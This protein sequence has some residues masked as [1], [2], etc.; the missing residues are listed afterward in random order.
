MDPL[1]RRLADA[2]EGL[3]IFT[4]AV[5]DQVNSDGTVNLRLRGGIVTNVECLEFYSPA[6]GDVVQAVRKNAAQYLVFGK[7]R[8]SAVT[9]VGVTSALAMPWKIDSVPAAAD[10]VD[11]PGPNIANPFIVSAVESRSYRSGTG[12]E[13]ADVYQGGWP[14]STQYGYWTGAWFYGSKPRAAA[15]VRVTRFRITLRRKSGVGVNYGG[16]PAVFRRHNRDTRPAGP[17]GIFSGGY[18][19]GSFA[20]GGTYTVDLPVQWGQQLI[21]G[22]IRGICVNSNSTS[23]Y[24]AFDGRSA[25]SSSGTLT[26][27]WA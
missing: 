12:W 16:H 26:I 21:T 22:Q 13:Y 27:N 8:T 10:P 4:A 23:D 20:N 25:Y 17:V 11:N 5:V 2:G 7:V 1:A 18:R 9:T 6:T 14:G 15:G 19:T 3:P 24:L